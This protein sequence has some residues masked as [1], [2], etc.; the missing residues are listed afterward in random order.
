MSELQTAK[1]RRT[2]RPGPMRPTCVLW[3]WLA[4]LL[5]VIAGPRP[6]FAQDPELGEVGELPPTGEP[7]PDEVGATAPTPASPEVQ[8]HAIEEGVD[9]GAVAPSEGATALPS[10][11][12]PAG[13]EA[14]VSAED[15]MQQQMFEAAMAAAEADGPPAPIAD[16]DPKDERSELDSQGC[17][18]DWGCWDL[19]YSTKGAILGVRWTLNYS[20]TRP[21]HDMQTGF[22]VLYALEHFATREALAVH[23]NSLAAIGGGSAGNEQAFLGELDLGFRGRHTERAGPFLRGGLSAEA[24]GHDTLSLWH[25][26]PLTLRAG[27]QLLDEDFVVEGG[28]TQGYIPYG[29]FRSDRGK[30]R[31]LARG[32][33]LG[34]YGVVRFA[35]FRVRVSALRIDPP[36]GTPLHAFR[37]AYCDYRLTATVC[38]ELGYYTTT[39][40][41]PTRWVRTHVPTLGVTFGFS[42]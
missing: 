1:S 32:N 35:P 15:A 26:E 16:D 36:S 31:E 19:I 3:G 10:D 13:A 29:R 34:V 37:A 20:R 8:P 40:E 7:A 27:Y 4:A 21:E 2:F 22:M 39:V 9:P 33:A 28:L 6:A 24:F 12:P 17:P 23:L 30:S 25:V 38:A 42:P 14:Q 11:Q 18:K 41:M 5:L